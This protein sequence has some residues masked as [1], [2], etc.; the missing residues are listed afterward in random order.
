ME[1]SADGQASYNLIQAVISGW[2]VGSGGEPGVPRLVAG[3]GWR[4]KTEIRRHRALLASLDNQDVA[5]PIRSQTRQDTSSGRTANYGQI[6]VRI[7]KWVA[8]G[9]LRL[10]IC[11][12]AV[13]DKLV[14][15]S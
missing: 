3:A 7:F 1:R 12:L 5:V 14:Q 2:T 8:A 4:C 6:T 10:E 13:G 15:F 11:N 9:E